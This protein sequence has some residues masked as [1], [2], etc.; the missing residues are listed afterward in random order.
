MVI[1]RLLYKK[2][3]QRRNSPSYL[4]S[5]RNRLASLRQKLLAAIDHDFRRVDITGSKLLEAMC[6]FCL[7]SS[8]SPTDVLKHFH[9]IRL[10]AIKGGI[11][12]GH[13][14]QTSTFLALRLYL[15]TLKDTTAYVPERLA[16]HLREIKS[17]PLF[18]SKDISSL[19]HFNLDVHG[20]WLGDDIMMFLPYI[21]YDELQ[22]LETQRLL[23][24]WAPKA[25][26]LFIDRLRNE[27]RSIDDPKTLAKVREQLLK[28]WLSS[29]RFLTTD[30]ASKNFDKLRDT[31]NSTFIVLVQSH[32]SSLSNLTLNIIRTLNGWQHNKSTSSPTLWNSSMTAMDISGGG[33]SFIESI[34]ARVNGRNAILLETLKEYTSWSQRVGAIERVIQDMKN[35]RW[36]EVANDFGAEDDEEDDDESLNDKQSFLSKDDPSFLHDEFKRSIEASFEKLQDSIHTQAERLKGLDR[37]AQIVYLLRLLREIKQYLPPSYHSI[38]LGVDSILKLQKALGELIIEVPWKHCQRQI[39]KSTHTGYVINRSLWEGDPELPRV[40][41]SWAYRLLHN[42]VSAMTAAGADVWSIRA[43]DILKTQLRNLLALWLESTITSKTQINGYSLEHTN[44]IDETA[45]KVIESCATNKR[46][47]LVHLSNDSKVQLSFD[48][49]YLSYATTLKGKLTGDIQDTLI[50]VHQQLEEDTRTDE[51]SRKALNRNAEEYW[52]RTSLLFLLLA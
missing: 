32:V 33:R 15:N 34:I 41:S 1:S 43:T 5:L 28:L 31:F 46:L 38:E 49:M 14:L 10:E 25:F 36:D 17:L 16:N 39:T 3:S 37:Q 40:P 29:P 30:D 35:I 12:E 8:S 20:Q 48:L 23:R 22:R 47:H 13:D 2:L 21:R 26:S 42:L 44:S 24:S 11:Y 18:K 19:L 7:A 6:A 45:E 52:K 50:R 51:R 9:R 4:D 27:L